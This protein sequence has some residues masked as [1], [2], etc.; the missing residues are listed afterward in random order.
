MGSKSSTKK[1]LKDSIGKPFVCPHCNE[2]FISKTS[3]K[4]VK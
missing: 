3:V 2:T 1:A 4:D